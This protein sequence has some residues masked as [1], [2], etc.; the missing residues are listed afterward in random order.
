MIRRVWDRACL[1]VSLALLA[2]LLSGG[3]RGASSPAPDPLAQLEALS[4]VGAA[5]LDLAAASCPALPPEEA[6]VCADTADGLSDLLQ[7]GVAVLE[8]RGE[9]AL[10]DSECA[11]AVGDLARER[12]PEIR[13]VLLRLLALTGRAPR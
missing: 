2:A 4:E 10:G 6:K 5:A 8:A 11:A 12:P 3:C 13:S 1:A 7:V 9:C